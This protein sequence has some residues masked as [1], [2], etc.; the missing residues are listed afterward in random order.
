[1]RLALELEREFP[2]EAHLQLP[3]ARWGFADFNEADDQHE[4]TNL[5][6]SDLRNFV[7]DEALSSGS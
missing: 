6:V 5:V 2:Y 7:E 1:L 3:V 4:R